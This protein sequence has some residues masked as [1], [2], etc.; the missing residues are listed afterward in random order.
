M[1]LVDCAGPGDDGQNRGAPPP[2][3]K[4]LIAIGDKVA[5]LKI[6]V[7]YADEDELLAKRV[8][9]PHAQGLLRRAVPRPLQRD[10]ARATRWLGRRQCGC[11]S[12][13]SRRPACA[14]AARPTSTAAW[15][16]RARGHE[17][18]EP[19]AQGRADALAGRR[20]R[21]HQDRPRLAGRA[22]GVPRAHPGRRARQ[23]ASARS[24]PCTA[25]ASTRWSGDPGHPDAGEPCSARQSAGGHLHDLRRQE[26]DRLAGALRRRPARSTTRRSIGNRP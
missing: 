21:G 7:Q 26:G 15:A 8:R 19:A 14:C 18:H 12:C 5:F 23:S 17:R 16:C 3:A 22:R 10:G 6:D 4:K 2:D 13:W 25:S 1:K 9:H 24:T 20:R 11:G